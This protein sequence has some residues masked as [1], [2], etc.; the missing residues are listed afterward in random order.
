MLTVGHCRPSTVCDP[1]SAVCVN[2]CDRL[3]FF[4]SVGIAPTYQP[5]FRKVSSW[6]CLISILVALSDSSELVQVSS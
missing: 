6:V 4:V 3:R 1:L 2:S 5:C